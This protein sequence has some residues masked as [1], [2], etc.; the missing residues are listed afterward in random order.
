ML[1]GMTFFSLP[2]P[3]NF[4]FSVRP[5]NWWTEGLLNHARKCITSELVAGD[6]VQGIIWRNQQTF[7]IVYWKHK[8]WRRK[9]KTRTN[10]LN[11]PLVHT[12][13]GFFSTNVTNSLYNRERPSYT[14]LSIVHNGWSVTAKITNIVH[15]SHSTL[16][17]P[18]LA[19]VVI[20]WVFYVFK[21]GSAVFSKLCSETYPC[22]QYWI[23]M[24]PGIA[25]GKQ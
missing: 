13:R 25:L 24:F 6:L 19:T 9:Q 21:M 5:K 17:V 7:V 16:T 12:A 15:H 18:S 8:I 10:S 11:V 20:I 22:Y 23:G 3:G 4:T 1:Q 14:F 2:C